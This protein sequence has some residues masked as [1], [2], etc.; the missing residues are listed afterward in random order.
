MAVPTATQQPAP[1][2]A[3]RRLVA[4]HPVA[5]FLVMV[6]T[7]NTAPRYR[8]RVAAL[9]LHRSARREHLRACPS[10][11]GGALRGRL[12]E[13]GRPRGGQEVILIPG[14]SGVGPPGVPHAWWNPSDDEEVRFLADI[15]PGLDVE[16]WLE[17]VLG[18]MRDGKT[19]GP[20]PRNPLQL[21]VLA[22]EIGSWLVL[23]PV[24]NVLFAPVVL[25]ALVGSLLGYRARYLE[26]S[27][28]NGQD[29]PVRHGR[30]NEAIPERKED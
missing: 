19:I 18:L 6:Y 12:G 23:T 3:L 16:T 22:R 5:A 2:S 13:D 24:E 14:Q 28:P 26:Y 10:R 17:T 29:A 7:V 1:H 30:R 15:R 9:R 11:P 4:R 25:L 20:I 27:G 21:A 8:G